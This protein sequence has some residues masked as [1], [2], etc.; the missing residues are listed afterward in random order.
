MFNVLDKFKASIFVDFLQKLNLK[1]G[2]TVFIP[3]DLYIKFYAKS[4][5]VS[6]DFLY[7]SP[8]FL[9]IIKNHITYDNLP[10]KK[11]T[12]FITLSNTFFVFNSTS[13]DPVI[14]DVRGEQ[15]GIKLSEKIITDQFTAYLIKGILI[16]NQEPFSFLEDLPK[17][18][19][20]YLIL[21]GNFKSKDILQLCNLS[22]NISAKCTD[23]LYIN[24]LKRLNI[25]PGDNAKETYTEFVT[26]PLIWMLKNHPDK[27]WG[28]QE[29]SRNPSIT[30]QFI[31]ENPDK[32]WNWNYLS[33]NPSITWQFIK[34][35]PDKN[36]NWNYMS[37]NPSITWEIVQKNI[38]LPWDWIWL[39]TNPSITWQI[40][41]DNLDKD[42]DWYSL[43]ENPFITWQNIQQNPDENWN[44]D[45]LSEN[46]NIT[47]QNVQDNP[48]RPWNFT[49]LSKNPNI[50]WQIV[51]DN[52]DEPWNWYGLSRNPSIT[53]QI[54]QDNPDK[55]W[56]WSAL[57]ENPNITWQIVQDN[58][59]KLWNWYRL[60]LNPGITW[61][62]VIKNLDKPWD[63]SGLSEKYL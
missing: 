28:W 35:N 60:S 62:D 63:W 31:K 33:E 9:N 4:F 39:S 55:P 2:F 13:S 58:P 30:W 49:Y 15:F 47:W 41:Q 40:V 29:L 22:K 53:W 42:W 21:V 3:S 7:K 27:P 34:E 52:P 6:I 19:F 26:N 23:A 59:N 12:R 10:L 38:D 1:P 14:D 24:L 17:D 11:K 25:D 54:V 18:P 32:P 61:E 44:W 16:Q 20:Q 56:Q 50:T 43:S 46:P 37:A 36:W 51:Q 5:K 48:Y 57:S 45:Y 8:I